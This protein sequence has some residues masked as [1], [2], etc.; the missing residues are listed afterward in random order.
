MLARRERQ[1]SKREPEC[2]ETATQEQHER[3]KGITS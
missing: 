2:A 3:G 1:H